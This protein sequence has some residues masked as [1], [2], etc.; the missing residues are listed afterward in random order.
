MK[1]QNNPLLDNQEKIRNQDKSNM[2]SFCINISA[3]YL[4]AYQL[5]KAIQ[6]SYPK[7]NSI[8]FAGMGGSAIGGE[9]LKDWAK[10]KIA[11]PIEV[12]R[13]YQLPAYAGKTTLVIVSSYSGETEESLSAFLDAKKRGCMVFCGSSGGALLKYAEALD[14]PFLRV[15]SGMPPRAALPYMLM[16]LLVCMERLGLVSGVSEEVTE[17]AEVLKQAADKYAPEVASKDNLAKT[18]ALILNGAV[19]TVYG[20]E[21]YRSVSQRFKQQINENCKNPPN[22]KSSLS[23]TT[24]RL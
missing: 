15:P 5:A 24:T 2:L 20:F 12:N 19:T 21:I 7:P 17:A 13:D 8:I 16:A 1:P 4:Q 9:L 18:L 3:N 6:L 11:V 14:V 22:G 23:L 10:D